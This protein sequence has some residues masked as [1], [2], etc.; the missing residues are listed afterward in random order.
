[1]GMLR[2]GTEPEYL[3]PTM[4]NLCYPPLATDYHYFE[5]PRIQ[6]NSGFSLA[7]AA[8]AADASMLA[9]GRSRMTRFTAAEFE[10]I[11]N[12][13]GLTLFGTIG[14]C[15]ADNISTGRGYLA[16]T[17]DFAVL[18]FRGTEADN[19]H[20]VACDCELLLVP[21]ESLGAPAAGHVHIGFQNYLRRAWDQVARLV[22]DWRAGHPNQEICVTGHSLGGALA[23]L[24]FQQL[25]DPRSSLYTYG[26]PRVGNHEFCASLE[27]MAATRG[28]YRIVD[29]EDMVTHIPVPTVLFPYA[30]P[31]CTLEWIDA[32][33]QV[34]ENPA[35][36][37]G[38]RKDITDLVKDF[39]QGNFRDPIPGPV[40]DHS[41]VRYC[42]WLG[43]AVG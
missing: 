30:H 27:A 37:P 40:A 2:P 22:A 32:N 26:C 21:Q 25:N 3:A 9:Y 23:T 12:A 33:H 31:S 7:N 16:G 34:I 8:F 10:A 13:A 19:K 20:D 42:Q 5:K 28:C 29:H 18:A 17:G 39:L 6:G 14:E 1:M 24:A 15:F 11:L 38:D 43:Q 4:A 36:P 41:P 35:N